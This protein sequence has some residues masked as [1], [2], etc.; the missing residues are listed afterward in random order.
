MKTQAIFIGIMLVFAMGYSAKA[1]SP[2]VFKY[3]NNPTYSVHNYKQPNHA[4]LA[5]KYA[6]EQRVELN[7]ISIPSE[8]DKNRRNYKMPSSPVQQV[9]PAGA[10]VPVTKQKKQV[11]S[12][13]SPANYKRQ[14]K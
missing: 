8:M 3:K 11:N 9:Q 12:V 5:E 1:Q 10:T 2:V 4:K 13:Q 6:L 7:Y 14:F